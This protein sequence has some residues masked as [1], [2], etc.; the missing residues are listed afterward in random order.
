MVPYIPS[1]VFETSVVRDPSP[2]S[3]PAREYLR[4][5]CVVSSHVLPL[6]RNPGVSLC[7]PETIPSTLVWVQGRLGVIILLNVPLS[8]PLVLT[9]PEFPRGQQRL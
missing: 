2:H 4:H 8:R 9:R 1:R 5:F 6:V 3:A 7:V